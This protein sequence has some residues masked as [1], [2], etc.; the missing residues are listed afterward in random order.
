MEGHGIWRAEKS[1]NPELCI[2]TVYL[3]LRDAKLLLR[4]F[5]KLKI[6]TSFW[7]M[8]TSYEGFRISNSEV[9]ALFY[10]DY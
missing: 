8:P 2:N 7:G 1:T 3:L 4:D 5:Y 10:S 9:F 6:N